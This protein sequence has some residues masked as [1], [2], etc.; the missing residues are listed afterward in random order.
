MIVYNDRASL[1][2]LSIN[3]TF[4]HL[5]FCSFR[6]LSLQW[7]ILGQTSSIQFGLCQQ[8]GRALKNSAFVFYLFSKPFS[9]QTGFFL[10]C[11][12]IT[13]VFVLIK[14]FFVLLR[15]NLSFLIL[16]CIVSASILSVLNINPNS[17]WRVHMGISLKE[18]QIT[19]EPMKVK[20]WKK[21][22]IHKHSV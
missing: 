3:N 19:E 5:L 4:W 6:Y 11:C 14:M 8:M 13:L 21:L 2:T 22:L 15:F 1:H 16:C 10:F 9:P 12:W 7:C 17:L 20:I 18:R